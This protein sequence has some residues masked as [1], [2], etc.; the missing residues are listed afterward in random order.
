MTS[1][2]LWL[3]ETE[4]KFVFQAFTLENAS[5]GSVTDVNI[6]IVVG[7]FTADLVAGEG[8]LELPIVLVLAL[9]VETSTRH[10]E[11]D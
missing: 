9:H 7:T 11:V 1:N 4:F 2:E 10:V 5:D 3:V 6:T 8:Q